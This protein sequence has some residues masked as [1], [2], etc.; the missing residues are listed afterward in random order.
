MRYSR[1]HKDQTR[2]KV[3]AGAGRAFRMHGRAGVG[4]DALA[5]E[6]GVTSGAFYTHFESKNQAFQ[7]AVVVGMEE[8]LAGI[9]RF[10][11]QHAG[12]WFGAF[13][14]WYLGRDH[15]H[16]LACGCALVSLSPEVIR[17]D[18]QTRRAY[19]S[20]VEVIVDEIADGLGDGPLA[21]RRDRARVALS[22]LAGAVTLSRA[23]GDEASAKGIADAARSALD[24]LIPSERQTD[25]NGN[26]P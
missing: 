23:V 2:A 13:A 21:A 15:R 3:V 7:A 10:R 1:Q 22:L 16:D 11:Q 17:A 14:D 19:A 9:R 20:V 6:A 18:D 24:A 5:K 8:L 12:A 25:R 26:V 4:V